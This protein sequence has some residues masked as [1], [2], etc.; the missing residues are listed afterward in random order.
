[1]EER[2]VCSSGTEHTKDSLTCCSLHGRV[3]NLVGDP[4]VMIR[5]LDLWVATEL[6]G[7]DGGSVC[8][9]RVVGVSVALGAL[10]SLRPG[11]D[12]SLRI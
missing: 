3:S 7:G 2:V 10:Q 6:V 11:F 8:V 5:L 4:D 9:H 1:M 12:T